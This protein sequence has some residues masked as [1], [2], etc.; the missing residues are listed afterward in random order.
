MLSV[1]SCQVFCCLAKGQKHLQMMIK[2]QNVRF[3]FHRVEKIMGTGENAAIF[4]TIEIV[5]CKLFQFGNV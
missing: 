3:L 2:T 4:I 5:V 1:W